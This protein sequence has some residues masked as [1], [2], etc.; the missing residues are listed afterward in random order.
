MTDATVDVLNTAGAGVS[1]MGGRRPAAFRQRHRRG[2][3]HGG[4][5]AGGLP[6]GAR[7]ESHELGQPVLVH[8]IAG[9][10][11]WPQYRTQAMAV[12]DE[13]LGPR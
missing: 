5:G 11:R 4:A 3:L 7:K 12:G 10:D 1:L 2:H 8:D 13:S 9:T 6:D